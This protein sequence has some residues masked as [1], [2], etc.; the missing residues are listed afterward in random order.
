[1]EIYKLKAIE[2][3][4]K[5]LKEFNEQKAGRYG[6]VVKDAVADALLDFC[7]QD[8]EFA[9]AIV[10][11]DKTLTECCKEIMNNCGNSIS[12]L[13]VYKRAVAFYFPGAGIN[14]TMTIDLCASVRD[15]EA[16]KPAGKVIDLS[17]SDLFG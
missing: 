11:A 5:E 9:Q 4:N 17:L 1:M 3:I 6:V 15:G 13:E 16:D 7:R 2:K 8:D 10:Q 14:M 12:D